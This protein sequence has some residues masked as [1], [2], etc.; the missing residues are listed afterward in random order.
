MLL[1]G[2][3]RDKRLGNDNGKLTTTEIHG[4]KRSRTREI[5]FSVSRRQ[6]ILEHVGKILAFGTI[7]HSYLLHFIS[8]RDKIIIMFV[9]RLMRITRT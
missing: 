6:V 9:I 4:R 2:K 8:A 7:I 1:R 3:E 5:I